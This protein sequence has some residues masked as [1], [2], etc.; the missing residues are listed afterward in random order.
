MAKRALAGQAGVEIHPTA[1][2]DREA[3]LDE[4][5]V[6]GP[7]SVIGPEVRIGSGTVLQSGVVVTGK[8]TIGKRNMIGHHSVI[9]T[10]PQLLKSL[11]AEVG[12]IIGD[13]NIIRE[14]TTINTG[15]EHGG[16]PTRIGNHCYLMIACH[17]AHDCILCD[18]SEIMNNVLLAGHVRVEEGAI[19][20]G[21]AG[22]HHFVTVGT[23]SF[24]G[25]LSKVVQDV[26]PFMLI[27]GNPARVRG[28]NVVGL[29]RAGFSEKR[30]NALKAAH[31]VLYRSKLSR[32]KALEKLER[33][34]PG[35]DV[36]YLVKFCR[37]TASGKQG[38][39]RE[40]LRKP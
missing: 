38:R 8:V 20:S 2:V 3:V 4:G 31:R 6:I 10:K 22:V 19:I 14:G 28:V 26:P 18:H 39:A 30:I 32:S 15:T 12:V 1:V 13:E 29:R 37:A 21:G 36:A 16:G 25:G 9:G 34:S 33:E 5:V 7:H 24:S 27:D 40:A 17:V 35:A 11:G 23:L